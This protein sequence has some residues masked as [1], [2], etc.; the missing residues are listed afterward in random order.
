MSNYVLGKG[1]LYFDKFPQN[2]II[3]DVLRGEGERYIGNSPE[4]ST[5]SASENLDHFSAEGGIRT[6]DDSVQLSL[7]R[8]GRFSTDE[9]SPENLA[10]LFLGE[11]LAVVDAGAT[12]EIDV[13]TVTPDRFYQLGQSAA[14][15]SG[16][17]KVSNVA[18]KTGTPGFATTVAASGN[19][20]VDLEL[21][22]IYILADAVAIDADEII[23][24]TYDVAASTREQVISGTNSI[25]GALRFVADNPKGVNK[26]Y[27]WPYVQLSAD[28]DFALKSEEWQVMAF[29]FEV[30]KKGTAASVYIDGRAEV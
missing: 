21:G 18:V 22:R 25:T 9:V 14:T 19:Y 15:P 7:D 1:R 24:V 3:N 13:L 27:Y 28:G 26:D 2:A 8:S 30:L 5:S 6:K 20:T 11:A 23:Q 12:G 16:V 10:L 4:L 17:R 29:T